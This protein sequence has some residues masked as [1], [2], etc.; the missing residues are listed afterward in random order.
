MNFNLFDTILIILTLTVITSVLF[1]YIRLPV[2]LGYLI[3][4]AIVGP[5]GLEWLKDISDIRKLAEFGIVFLMFMVGLEFSLSRLYALRH[6]VFVLGATQVL[7]SISISVVLGMVFNM[8]LTEA[9]IIGGIIAMSST[10]IVLK[11]LDNQLE[12]NTPHGTKAVGILLF[13]DIAVVPF[14]ILI[15]SLANKLPQVTLTASFLS[16]AIKSGIVITVMVSLGRW[17]IR[18]L[19]RVIAATRSQELFTLTALLITLGGAWLTYN[20]GLSLALGAFIAGVLLG[21]SQF[22][23]QIKV[24]VR[25]FRDIFLGLFFI[26]I[27]MLVATNHWHETWPWILLMLFGLTIGKAILIMLLVRIYKNDW[28]TAFRTAIILA[29]GGEFGF[30]ILTLALN[31]K[32]LPE[33]YVQVILAALVLSIAIAPIIIQSNEAITKWFFK[34]PVL[35]QKKHSH[36]CH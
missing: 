5:H 16:I 10:A 18:P 33:P 6:S 14:F 36:R 15:T 12:I 13:Q 27:G 3:I 26:S 23:H 19:F 24:E 32:L 30:A 8:N 9:L 7:I 28:A 1:R 29:Q 4:G 34:K 20:M 2:I 21:D 25:P 35:K 22:R 31:Q 17:A 11:Q